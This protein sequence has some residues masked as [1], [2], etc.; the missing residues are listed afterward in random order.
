M[1]KFALYYNPWVGG[2]K[3][4]SYGM[5]PNAASTNLVGLAK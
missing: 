5:Q 4:Y 3:P 1:E 2:G